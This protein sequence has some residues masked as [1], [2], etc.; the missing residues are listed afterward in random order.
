MPGM[1]IRVALVCLPALLAFAPGAWAQPRISAMACYAGD[2][3]PALA[4]AWTL[5]PLLLPPALLLLLMSLSFEGTA[6]TTGFGGGWTLYPPLAT[7]G[8]P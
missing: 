4:Q 3:P 8:H 5:S 2:A 7:D 6:G 1:S